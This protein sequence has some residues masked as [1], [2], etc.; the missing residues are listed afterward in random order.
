MQNAGTVIVRYEFCILH[1]FYA[2][3]GC[4]AF[5]RKWFDTSCHELKPMISWILALRA[6]WIE[7][8]KIFMQRS[9]NHVWRTIH[10]ALL[11]ILLFGAS[12]PVALG[13][14]HYVCPRQTAEEQSAA[15]ALISELLD[16]NC[17]DYGAARH[18]CV[19]VGTTK[20][21]KYYFSFSYFNW[22]F[23]AYSR[24]VEPFFFLK[25]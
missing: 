5:D 3:F 8:P 18:E 23:F 16:A 21:E 14:T 4:T 22:I 11:Q 17:L 9:A 24:G 10:E 13:A 20:F 1:C 15:F 7:L 6:P 2:A 12:A 25:A 19:Q